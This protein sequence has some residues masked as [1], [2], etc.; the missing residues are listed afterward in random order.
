MV[1]TQNLSSQ[2]QEQAKDAKALLTEQK[3]HRKVGKSIEGYWQGSYDKITFGA[4]NV[5]MRSK[6]DGR[7]TPGKLEF[8]SKAGGASVIPKDKLVYQRKLYALHDDWCSYMR[9]YKNDI[10]CCPKGMNIKSLRDAAER[11]VKLRKWFSEHY[12]ALRTLVNDKREVSVHDRNLI[13]KGLDLMQRKLERMPRVCDIVVESNAGKSKILSILREVTTQL[14]VA[15][16][17]GEQI[18][19]SAIRALHMIR[20]Q[21][22]ELLEGLSQAYHHFYTFGVPRNMSVQPHLDMINNAT[23]NWPKIRKVQAF[24]DDRDCTPNIKSSKIP[25]QLKTTEDYGS[26]YRVLS[27]ITAMPDNGGK[28]PNMRRRTHRVRVAKPKIQRDSY[29]GISDYGVGYYTEEQR[30]VKHDPKDK[31]RS[32]RKAMFRFMRSNMGG[33]VI[34]KETKVER[35]CG[36][37]KMSSWIKI[38]NKEG[39]YWPLH[40]AYGKT[41]N[42]YDVAGTQRVLKVEPPSKGRNFTCNSEGVVGLI[43]YEGELN[44]EVDGSIKT[45]MVFRRS[46]RS[47]QPLSGT[48]IFNNRKQ[49]VGIVT[50]QCK[51]RIY[52]PTDNISIL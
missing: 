3:S 38:A 1:I 23:V 20:R 8:V 47:G 10:D 18:N 52:V 12:I 11:G 50:H 42:L 16:Q 32:Q 6:R 21:A 9:Q 17:E 51:G 46:K 27:E 2:P 40:A 43:K 44:V 30:S 36:S 41:C 29:G 34:T 7:E 28:A 37:K 15:Y 14:N 49:L 5:V 24:V 45:C 22:H 39:S 33:F 35:D 19:R 26:R 25:A 48:P 31:N 4:G 13:E